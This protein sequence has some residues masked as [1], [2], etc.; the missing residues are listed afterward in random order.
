[1]Y[2][3]VSDIASQDSAAPPDHFS[4]PSPSSFDP[5]SARLTLRGAS[6]LKRPAPALATMESLQVAQKVRY[7][8]GGS[9]GRV[10][11]SD[12]DGLYSAIVQLAVS[13]YQ[14][15]LANSSIY[16]SDAESRDWSGEAWGAACRA[17]GVKVEYDEDAYKLVRHLAIM[18]LSCTCFLSNRSPHVARTYGANS[19]TLCAPSS[20]LNVDSSMKKLQRL[21]YRMLH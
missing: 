1:M 8:E 3:S 6:S 9:R 5:G 2:D 21:S 4:S 20:K 19:R 18:I 11:C 14:C 15:I 17:N 10:R 16:P 13:H 7:S 12:F